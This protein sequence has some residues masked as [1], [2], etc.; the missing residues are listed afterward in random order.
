MRQRSLGLYGSESRVAIANAYLERR[1]GHA[2]SYRRDRHEH[3]RPRLPA[4]ACAAHPPRNGR[5]SRAEGTSMMDWYE[6]SLD[7]FVSREARRRRITR[8]E[9]LAE[10]SA[11]P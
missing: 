10:A 8:E 1:R 9:L 2:A 4:R 6:K 3:G 7:D 11:V 5:N